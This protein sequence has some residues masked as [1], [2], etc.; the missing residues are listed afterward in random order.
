MRKARENILVSDAS[1]DVFA[2]N[3]DVFTVSSAGE[4]IINVLPKQLVVYNPLTNKSLSAGD[5]FTDARAIVFAMGVDLNGDG[6]SDI[7]R[8]SAGESI[9]ASGIL[10]A[11]AEPALCGVP[12]K[13][14]FL[15]ECV[16]C[17]DVLSVNVGVFNHKIEGLFPYNREAIYTYT[18][19]NVCTDCANCSPTFDGDAA[20]N[21][22][23][24]ALNGYKGDW[25]VF[26][27]GTKVRAPHLDYVATRLY[28]NTYLFCL[29]GTYA[30]GC[31]N[32]QLPAIGGIN[33]TPAG[34]VATDFAFDLVTFTGPNASEYSLPTH[35]DSIVSQINDLIAANGGH[36]TAT[37]SGGTGYCCPYEIEI[38]TDLVVT[39]LLGADGDTPASLLCAT[40]HPLT[41]DGKTWDYGVRFIQKKLQYGCDSYPANPPID[42]W[43]TLLNVYPVAGFKSGATSVIDV[44]RA[45]SPQNLG[46]DWQWRDYASDNGGVGRGQR[47]YNHHYGPLGLPLAGDRA[48]AVQVECKEHYCSYILEQGVFNTDTSVHARPAATRVRTVI[49]IPQSNTTAQT[50]F[51][52]LLNP[53]LASASMKLAAITC[54]EDEDQSTSELNYVG[55]ID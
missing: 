35:L 45:T 22:L 8:T 6:I 33:L 39:D 44:Q 29:D 28:A 24:D 32:C 18:V 36:G 10:S 42:E 30:G 37:W 23:V 53:I 12:A 5:D 34:D 25:D 49:L 11:A 21:K 3:Q 50:S 38:N 4:L 13:K 16:D 46:Y 14:D 27:N 9:S 19:K 40:T 2:G 43:F 20:A 51:E 1:N 7:L 15:F 41:V 17:F 26:K 52:A 31:T 47:G 54:S 55:K 48:N